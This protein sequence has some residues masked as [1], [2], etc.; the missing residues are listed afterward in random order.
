V[1]EKYV[2][3]NYRNE[4]TCGNEEICPKSIRK[5]LRWFFQLVG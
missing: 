1:N 2:V 4:W 5:E 3:N